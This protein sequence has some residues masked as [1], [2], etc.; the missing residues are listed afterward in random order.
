MLR[1]VKYILKREGEKV[2]KGEEWVSGGEE[3]QR[4]TV[5]IGERLRSWRRLSRSMQVQNNLHGKE[6]VASGNRTWGLLTP[7]VWSQAVWAGNLKPNSSFIG[8]F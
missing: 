5:S 4:E 7:R 3:E 1:R 2:G 6:A 8:W